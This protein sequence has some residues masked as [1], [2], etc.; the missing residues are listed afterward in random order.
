MKFSNG[1]LNMFKFEMA[2]YNEIEGGIWNIEIKLKVIHVYPIPA[3]ATYTIVLL[4]PKLLK[5]FEDV[6]LNLGSEK[7]THFLGQ[8]GHFLSRN[9]ILRAHYFAAPRHCA[10]H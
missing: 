10:A 5:Y 6:V 3:P 8:K 1:A 7:G 9:L 4:G 2:H